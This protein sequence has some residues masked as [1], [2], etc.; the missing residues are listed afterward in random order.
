MDIVS[1]FISSYNGFVNY[2]S[3]FTWKLNDNF[4]TISDESE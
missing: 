2:D 4:Y 1:I 3:I